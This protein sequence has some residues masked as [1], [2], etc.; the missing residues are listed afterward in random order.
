MP[1]FRNR[2]KTLYCGSFYDFAHSCEVHTDNLRRKW[3]F[4]ETKWNPIFPLEY[5]PHCLAYNGIFSILP[6][7]LAFT[8]IILFH[9]HEH[10]RGNLK[11]CI[12]RI[13][14]SEEESFDIHR[15]RKLAVC[16]LKP[17]AMNLSFSQ[18]LR[19]ERK[20]F[21]LSRDRKLVLTLTLINT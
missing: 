5:F 17:R 13:V 1:N 12:H 20:K 4:P 15:W 8:I 11:I 6:L 16:S 3:I 18:C 2:A 21:F 7:P 19:H 14:W 9:T 10:R